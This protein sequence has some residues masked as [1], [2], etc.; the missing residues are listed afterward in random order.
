MPTAISTDVLRQR[1]VTSVLVDESTTGTL[2]AAPSGSNG[3]TEQSFAFTEAPAWSQETDTTTFSETGTD[4]IT[5]DQ[6][7][8]RL[9]YAT[10]TFSV[11]AKPNGVSAPAES[12][13]L[14]KFFGTT[15]TS[16]QYG[17][18]FSDQVASDRFGVFDCCCGGHPQ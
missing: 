3:S 13:L 1:A 7:L 2:S 8:N 12:Y 4:I 11:L 10:S 15:D 16:G 18:Y 6:S 14:T 5:Q 9:E 17:Y